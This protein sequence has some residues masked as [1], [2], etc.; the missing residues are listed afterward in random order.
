MLTV[1]RCA[2]AGEALIL[3]LVVSHVVVGARAPSRV[4][5]SEIQYLR[6]LEISQL[7]QPQIRYVRIRA[8]GERVIGA[9]SQGGQGWIG[10]VRCAPPLSDFIFRGVSLYTFSF[11]CF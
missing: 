5:C 8:A 2:G 9:R 11:L 10:A 6:D 3:L 7:K 4:L 1:L